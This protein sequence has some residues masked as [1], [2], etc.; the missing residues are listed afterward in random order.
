MSASGLYRIYNS[1]CFEWLALQRA[2]SFQAVV[3]DPPFGVVEYSTRELARKRDGNRGLWR[4]PQAFDGATRQPMP[5]FTTLSKHDRMGVLAFHLRLAPEL[6]RV[7]VPGAHVMIASQCLISHL[8]AQAFD[9]TG[10]EVR[11]QIVRVVKTL[12]GGDRPKFG[13]KIY[14]DVS[15]IPRSHF[16]PW[17]L[18]RKP[19]EG[20]VVDNLK[21]F[22]TGALRRPEVDTPF[23]DLIEA[24]PAKKEERLISAH[25]SLKPQFLMRQLVRA[26]LPLGKGVILDPFM[27]SGSTIAAALSLGIRSVGVEVDKQYFLSAKAD[28]P[29]L[30][31]LET[32][33]EA[34]RDGRN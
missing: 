7:L 23:S 31:R 19:C 21:R 16:E 4:L 24:P 28:I 18:F 33:R 6:F 11:G 26:S 32:K 10:F 17:L 9:M 2:N 3:T 29:K 22:G 15:V 5:R 12:R 34:K 8:V 1:D 30:A 13:D 14:R 27:G 20:R 25:P